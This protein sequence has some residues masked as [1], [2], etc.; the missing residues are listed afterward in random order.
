MGS[1]RSIKIEIQYFGAFKNRF[2]TKN[3][4]IGVPDDFNLALYKVKQRVD[5]H[6]KGVLYSILLNGTHIN[7]LDINSTRIKDG[8]T[9]TVIPV[10]LG[11]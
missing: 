4:M 9:V 5:H 11:G 8:D 6:L 10:V 3:E 1:G 7:Q 2:G